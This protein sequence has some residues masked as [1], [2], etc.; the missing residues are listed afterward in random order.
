MPVY[1][2]LDTMPPSLFI[3]VW[4]GH[5]TQDHIKWHNFHFT[6]FYTMANGC[7]WRQTL[8][9]VSHFMDTFCHKYCWVS[10]ANASE[11]WRSLLSPAAASG[12]PDPGE[13]AA[14][15]GFLLQQM[16]H[17][18]VCPHP[19]SE[20]S[21]FNCSFLLVCPCEIIGEDWRWQ[22]LSLT[23]STQLKWQVSALGLA[24]GI[25]E[26]IQKIKISIS[27]SLSMAFKVLKILK[28]RK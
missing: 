22:S 15:H 8:T 24:Q 16:K 20:C 1:H 18:Q 9:L 14:R 3:I 28:P 19:I 5:H 2:K 7:I 17:C 6:Q 11:S 13:K 12:V 21:T 27:I 26:V 10:C 4:D 23:M 25:W